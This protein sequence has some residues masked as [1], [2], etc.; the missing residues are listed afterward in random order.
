MTTWPTAAAITYEQSLFEATLSGGTSSPCGTFAFDTP[1]I[2]PNAG[3]AFHT[4]TFT[5]DNGNYGT[6]TNTVSVTVN[7]ATSTIDTPPTATTLTEGQSLAASVLFDGVT[8]VPGTFAFDAP[9]TIPSAGTASHAVTFTPTDSTN[10][11]TASTT[12]SVTVTGTSEA[13]IYV[14]FDAGTPEGTGAENDPVDTI[15]TALT[16]V[17]AEGTI[18]IN[19]GVT[20]ETITII[21]SVTLQR[22][23][24][25]GTVLIRN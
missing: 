9:S 7:K 19:P 10:Y 2:E 13:I 6:L 22:N 12:V 14:D 18:K 25:T 16:L 20:T 11:T 1:G 4:V 15:N 23:S 3:T 21:Q 17:Q 24:A 8:S 5:P